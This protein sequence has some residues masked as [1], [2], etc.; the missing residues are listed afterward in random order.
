MSKNPILLFISLF[1]LVVGL[2]IAAVHFDRTGRSAGDRKYPEPVVHYSFFTQED[3][4]EQAYRDAAELPSKEAL[5]EFPSGLLVNHH[6]L[7]SSF[8]AEAFDRAATAVPVTVLLISPNH[9]SAGKG[10]VILSESVWRTPYGDVQSDRQL[11]RALVGRGLASV[12]ETPFSQEHGISGIVAFI[13]KSMPEAKIVPVIVNDRLPIDQARTVADQLRSLLP[14]NTIIVGSFDF[15]HYLPSRAADFHDLFSSAAVRNFDFGSIERLD[16]DS[17]P[18]LALFLGLLQG[19][20]FHQLEH[21]NS[22]RLVHE[23]VLE[24]TSYV[25]GYFDHAG[26]AAMSAETLLALGPI[27]ISPQVRSALQ[28]RDPGYAWTYLER[29]MTGQGKT[30]SF[31]TGGDSTD[32]RALSRYGIEAVLASRASYQV[33]SYTV[34]M[35]DC[36]SA[37]AARQEID[38]GAVAVLCE[39]SKRNSV[40]LYKNK[41]IIFTHGD[42][43]SSSGLAGKEQSLAVG[44]A[45]TNA[46]LSA[47]LFPVGF[48]GK[49]Q[50]LLIGKE[51][52]SVLEEMSNHSPVSETVKSQIKTGVINFNFAK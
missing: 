27:H 1:C 44:V 8:I 30:A 15:S 52:D 45:A 41:P 3:P 47:Y 38:A 35:R 51:N 50:K 10:T 39:G 2:A 31:V 16:I 11:A 13:K 32:V 33:G 34:V 24:T 25:T 26:S 5:Q 21:S 4:Y 49:D 22:A 29:F 17:H 14:P 48:D 18:G 46:G 36:S 23:D 40:E 7:A 20:Q 28:R 12:E 19:P 6:L 43:L 9:F 42:L 37:A